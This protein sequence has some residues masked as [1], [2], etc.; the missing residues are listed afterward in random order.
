[1]GALKGHER[2]DRRSLAL[3]AAIAEKLRDRPELMDIARDNLDRWSQ[4]VGRSQ[5]Y[6]DAWREILSLPLPEILELLTEDSERMRA[7]RQ[8]TPFAGVLEP[9]ERWAIYRRFESGAPADP[10][11]AE[12]G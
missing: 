5:P 7:M 8:A 3:H 4:S 10:A 9:A 1:M 2:I 11:P 12:P 6:W